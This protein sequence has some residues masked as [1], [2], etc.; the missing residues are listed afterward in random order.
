MK[1][2]ASMLEHWHE[3]YLLLGTAAGTLV[4]LLFVAASIGEGYLNTRRAGATRTFMSPVVMHYA[5]VLFL[6]LVALAPEEEHGEG[7]RRKNTE[8]VEQA[9]D[10]VAVST[11]DRQALS[12]LRD[13]GERRA[14]NH[15]HKVTRL[16]GKRAE[17]QQAED[18]ED[19]RVDDL[20]E[21]RERLGMLLTDPG[22]KHLHR[23]PTDR[24]DQ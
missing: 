16:A 23:K 8:H 11:D 15:D 9:V 19:A 12:V 13:Q 22:R 6:S 4:A 7:I 18:G 3:F 14:G 10:H 5:S 20:V 2:A 17:P 24:Q 1:G 21:M